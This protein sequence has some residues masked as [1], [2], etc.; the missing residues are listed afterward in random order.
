ML[1]EF[2]LLSLI[3]GGENETL[4]FKREINLGTASSKSEFIKDVLSI[5]NS[6]DGE[7][8]IIVG[9]D[10]SSNIVGITSLEEERI[11]QIIQVYITPSIKINC[12]TVTLSSNSVNVGVL[13]ISGQEKP[14][15]IARAIDRL[16]Q[17]D[18]FL[19][20]GS[21]VMRASPEEIIRLHNFS[22][23][24]RRYRRY[25]QAAKKSTQSTDFEHA[26]EYYSK[27]LAE[28]YSAD[29]LILRG[30]TYLNWAI[31]QDKKLDLYTKR[32]GPHR[33]L[34][35]IKVPDAK[36]Q[37]EQVIEQIRD[38]K[39]S[40]KIQA[41]KD[42]S[43][44]VIIADTLETEKNARMLRLEWLTN[45]EFNV[46]DKPAVWEEDLAWLKS[47]AEKNEHTKVLYLEIKRI[48]VDNPYFEGY[49]EQVIPMMNEIIELGFDNTEIYRMRSMAH[50]GAH[51]Y[52]FA[53]SDIME[54]LNKANNPKDTLSAHLEYANILSNMGKYQELFNLFQ[55]L[56]TKYTKRDINGYVQ[57]TYGIV[58]EILLRCAI[59]FEFTETWDVRT[60]RQIT[61]LFKPWHEYFE[62]EHPDPARIIK[63]I[64]E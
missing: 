43:E 19:R 39:K 36:R 5:A 1:T 16:N 64:I 47:R 20:H 23:A 54:A 51:N 25:I 55:E 59:D 26:I 63:K 14:H 27:A 57:C 44:A 58:K 61:E 10:D 17:N 60:I 49:Y 45:I 31:Q 38:R 22:K 48:S 34:D 52:G 15:K 41:F 33:Y 30:K 11:Q 40:Y 21:V 46:K 12:S 2:Q 50:T 42:F 8:Y 6:A 37:A 18:V 9:V 7:G 13:K 29:A 4:D 32:L 3:E 62:R 24:H 28:T 35:T 53:L 56:K